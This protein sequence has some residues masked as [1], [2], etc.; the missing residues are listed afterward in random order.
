MNPGQ[1]GQRVTVERKSGGR[2]AWGQPL[3]DTWTPLVTVWASVAPLT[4]REYMAAGAMQSSV[5]T[6]IRMR[7]RPGITPA[8]RVMHEGRAYGIES[9]IDIRSQRREL[10]LMC[11]G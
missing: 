7:Y 5:T 11:M 8:D 3:P 9:V 4:G 2:D 6:R 10:V 1:L